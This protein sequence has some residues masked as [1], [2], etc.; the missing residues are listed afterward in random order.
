MASSST[1]NPPPPPSSSSTTKMGIRSA[2]TRSRTPESIESLRRRN[3]AAE[4]LE[5]YEKLSWYS[6]ARCEVSISFFCNLFLECLLTWCQTITQTRIHFQCIVAGITAAQEEE[7]VYWKEDFT[8]H[9]MTANQQQ[10]GS[11]RKAGKERLSSGSA[12]V[13]EKSGVE[14]SR[15]P[16]Q[17]KGK[18]KEVVGSL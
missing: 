3:E 12:T 7:N 11:S 17:H 15:S 14:G 1:R 10:Q 4:I 13:R 9:P 5:S 16:R 6:T 8:P 2:A 18:E